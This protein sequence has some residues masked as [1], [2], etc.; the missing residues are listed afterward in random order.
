MSQG[1]DFIMSKCL[2][3][4]SGRSRLSLPMSVVRVLQGLP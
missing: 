2:G 4:M 1:G 3:A